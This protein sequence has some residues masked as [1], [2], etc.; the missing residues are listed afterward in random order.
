MIG[1]HTSIFYKWFRRFWQPPI[2][3]ETLNQITGRWLV[4]SPRR[5]W[6]M[7]SFDF[8]MLLVWRSCW[9]NSTVVGNLRSRDI[10]AIGSWTYTSTYVI[11]EVMA[12]CLPSAKPLPEPV[13][14]YWRVWTIRSN[15]RW[16]LNQNITYFFQYN[17]FENV[18]WSFRPDLYESS[19]YPCH[20][21]TNNSLNLG[22][23]PANERRRYNVTTSLI[24]WEQTWIV[25]FGDYQILFGGWCQ[26]KNTWI[27]WL[28][29]I[30]MTPNS[31]RM[32]IK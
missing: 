22:L 29:E 23:R 15:F 26:L 19:E 4:D 24:G 8:C 6:K 9:T 25:C 11:Y 27:V 7:R 13:L 28:C 32:G 30:D 5:G 21:C 12:A 20:G 16:N 17:L 31:Y 18:K 3:M 10:T 2:V 1:H 14:T